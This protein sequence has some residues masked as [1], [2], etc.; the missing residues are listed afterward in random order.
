M[1]FAPHAID[2]VLRDLAG[3][4]ELVGSGQQQLFPERDHR[5]APCGFAVVEIEGLHVGGD[6]AE[7][8]CQQQVSE[9]G[10]D[11]RI[12]AAVVLEI[13]EGHPV[14]PHVR[15][16][17]VEQEGRVHHLGDVDR[18]ARRQ[19]ATHLVEHA[20]RRGHV[21][22]HPAQERGI[23]GPRFER[24]VRRVGLV[25][26]VAP[27]QP[28]HRLEVGAGRIELRLVEV[29]AG[30]VQFGKA[31]QQDLGLRADAAPHFEQSPRVAVVDVVEDRRFG[32][33]GLLHQARLFG[34]GEAVQIGKV[35]AGRRCVG[36][37]RTL[38]VRMRRCSHGRS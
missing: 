26:F 14:T 32:Q 37:G 11:E 16:V 20:G 36:H 31:A 5:L 21:F 8:A 2:D 38:G 4:D 1:H 22:E 12:A 3:L 30:R 13:V 28:R 23:E 33:P 18:R 15:R 10:A 25:Q 17:R 34:R 35:G 29:D 19:H 7:S 27:L 6:I 9:L 24:Q